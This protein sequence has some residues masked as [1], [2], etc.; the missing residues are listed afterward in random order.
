MNSIELTVLFTTICSP[1]WNPVISSSLSIYSAF[2]QKH[3]LTGEQQIGQEW[4]KW[5]WSTLVLSSE[6]QI[7]AKSW[8]S[9]DFGFPAYGKQR[10]EV[11]L[12]CAKQA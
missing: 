8:T 11:M 4:N 3:P 12:C 10:Q 2:Q 5:E 6:A 1:R 7:V 9:V